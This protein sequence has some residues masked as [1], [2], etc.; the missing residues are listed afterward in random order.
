M[1]DSENRF[2]D[3]LREKVK[4]IAFKRANPII[5]SMWPSSSRGVMF[6]EFESMLNELAD[7]VLRKQKAKKK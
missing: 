7:W 3:E 4:N 6:L 1:G 2:E 5:R